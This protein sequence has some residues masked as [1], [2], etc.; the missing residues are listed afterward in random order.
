[1]S[2]KIKITKDCFV[3]LDQIN[4]NQL[5]F[6]SHPRVQ[7][8][9]DAVSRKRLAVAGM[10]PGKARVVFRKGH[11]Y[12]AVALLIHSGFV[13]D[14]EKIETR[15]DKCFLWAVPAP[16][17]LYQMRE[18]MHKEIALEGTPSKKDL[19]RVKKRLRRK[20]RRIYRDIFHFVGRRGS[21]V[22]DTP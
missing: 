22:K 11:Y 12:E 1:M 5:H 13:G 20:K 17:F 9:V 6:P 21:K 19:D 16:Q 15:D 4:P 10:R 14:P 18:N 8:L 7:I 3:T 2:A